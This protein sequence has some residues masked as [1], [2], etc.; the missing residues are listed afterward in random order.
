MTLEGGLI[1]YLWAAV[2]DDA[3]DFIPCTSGGS[4]AN[5][6]SVKWVHRLRWAKANGITPLQALRHWAGRPEEPLTGYVPV[7]A[8]QEAPSLATLEALAASA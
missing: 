8:E 5:N 6:A 7:G 2:T 3:L 1:G 4:R